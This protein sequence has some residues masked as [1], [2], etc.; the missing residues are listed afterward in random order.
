MVLHAPA[1]KSFAFSIHYLMRINFDYS[2]NY[3]GNMVKPLK[4]S[5]FLVSRENR[6]RCVGSSRKSL[7]LKEFQRH[8]FRVSSLKESLCQKKSTVAERQFRHHVLQSNLLIRT[9]E[10]KRNRRS[11]I[12]E[13]SQAFGVPMPTGSLQETS[14]HHS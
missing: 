14:V 5:V 9:A 1:D 6:A 7:F 3:F 4:S 2:N 13:T 11:Q 10:E 12:Q 8:P